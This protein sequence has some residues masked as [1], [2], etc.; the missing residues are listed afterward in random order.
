MLI[1]AQ[2]SVPCLQFDGGRGLICRIAGCMGCS[3]CARCYKLTPL[4]WRHVTEEAAAIV[5]GMAR[6]SQIHR[7]SVSQSTLDLAGSDSLIGQIVGQLK[8]CL[9]FISSRP[10]SAATTIHYYSDCEWMQCDWMDSWCCSCSGFCCTKPVA[11][12]RAAKIANVYAIA[13]VVH[14]HKLYSFS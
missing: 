5:T 11:P 12:S 14:V 10:L 7:E 1:F 3:L 8:R 4:I 2:F 6:E 13:T 9:H